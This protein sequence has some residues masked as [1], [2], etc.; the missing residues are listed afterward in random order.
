MAAHESGRC[1]VDLQKLA[2]KEYQSRLKEFV[3]PLKGDGVRASA[4]V[5]RRDAVSGNHP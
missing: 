5:H 2:I 4:K 3:A 1:P